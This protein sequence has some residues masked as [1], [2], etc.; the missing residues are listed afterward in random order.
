MPKVVAC[1]SRDQAFRDFK[2]A[3]KQSQPDSFPLLL[4]DSEDPITKGSEPWDHLEQRDKWTK[5][6]KAD[7]KQFHLMVQ[8]MESWFLA[9]PDTLSQYFGRG[10]QN[11]ALPKRRDIE[12]IRKVDVYK[13]LESAS[14]NSQKQTYSKGKHSFALLGQI[15]PTKVTECSPFAQ[16]L[17]DAL[18]EFTE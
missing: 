15:D 16:R 8:C 13:L 4:V 10:F 3:L 12:N 14:R 7:D 18:K 1:G 5:P 11:S 17:I 6:S 2:T 9:D